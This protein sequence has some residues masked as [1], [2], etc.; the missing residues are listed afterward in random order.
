VKQN[1]NTTQYVLET[2][3]RKQTQIMSKSHEQSYKQLEVKTKWT[4][5][6][7]KGS[8]LFLH[9]LVSIN[10]SLLS[11]QIKGYGYALNAPFNNVSV[12]S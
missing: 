11:T 10:V 12:I 4:M 2:T 1:K 5:S 3:I 9:E 7:I 8:M 6:I